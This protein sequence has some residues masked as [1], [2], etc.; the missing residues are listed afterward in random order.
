MVL[1]TL[2]NKI[3]TI[4]YIT[5]QGATITRQHRCL[6]IK[7]GQEL[8][9]E[10]KLEHCEGLVLFG[11][12]HISEPALTLLLQRQIPTTF[13]S[14]MGKIKG[15]CQPAL[16]K[17]I[18]LRREQYLKCTDHSQ[19]LQL[20]RHCV[21][22]KISNTAE[23]LRFH[24]RAQPQTL[25]DQLPDEIKVWRAKALQATDINQLMGCEGYVAKTY[26]EAYGKLFKGGPG[27]H[28][29][30]YRPATD[31]V[32]ALLSLTYTLLGQELFGLLQARGLDPYLGFLHDTV[33]SRPS[34]ALDLLE[35]FRQPL[36]DRL[37]LRCFNRGELSVEDFGLAPNGL[38]LHLQQKS[39]K[40]YLF[41]YNQEMKEG[42]LNSTWGSLS[43]RQ[44]L[45]QQVNQLASYWLGKTDQPQ[46]FTF[47]HRKFP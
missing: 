5:E 46:F 10:I 13:L 20:A 16:G 30:V 6:L 38:G 1:S 44:H 22:N 47:C 27:F 11:R 15:Q 40:K 41:K 43:P 32:N 23:V 28:G 21:A 29:R 26:F 42:S 24:I 31:P 4:S 7:K 18:P 37:V 17:N 14:T 19:S 8:L 39:L 35:S 12:I 25:R 34:C 3:M 2:Y 33:H 45:Q 36:A 9:G